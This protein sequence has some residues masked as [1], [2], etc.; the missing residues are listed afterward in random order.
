MKNWFQKHKPNWELL[1]QQPW[2]LDMQQTLQ[3]PEWHAEGDVWTHT[4]MVVDALDSIPEFQMLDPDSQETLRWAALLHDVAKPHTTFFEEGRIVSPKH[5]LVGE[6]VARTLLWDMDFRRREHICA[7]VR[8]HGL[9]LWSLDKKNPNRSVISASLRTFNLWIYL[10]AK[11]DVLGRISKSVPEYL[12]RI[13]YFK[14]LCLENACFTAEKAFFNAHS[15]FRFFQTD[16]NYPAE[17]FDDTKFVITI[18][19]GLPGS[20]KDTLAAQLN[21]PMVSLDEIRKVLKIKADDREGQGRVAAEAYQMAKNYC[22]KKQPFVWNST[23]LTRMLRDRIIQTL[24][25]YNPCFRLIYLES[26]IGQMLEQRSD[27][28]PRKRLEDM[29]HRLD[30]PLQEEAHHVEYQR[31]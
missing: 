2:V 24:S 17:L 19:S 23:N 1:E 10:L 3:D 7:L 6:K 22:A 14:E 26:S 25:V 30:M 5:A 4:R 28:I 13:E 16:A 31:R 9:P 11:A 8:L 12:V 15:R 29:F 18:L 20:G 21:C 27:L